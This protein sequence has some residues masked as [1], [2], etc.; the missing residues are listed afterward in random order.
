MSREQFHRRQQHRHPRPEIADQIPE[1]RSHDAHNAWPENDRAYVHP[2]RTLLS[3]HIT[4]YAP[5]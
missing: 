4:T 2:L 1:E 3:E 5:L